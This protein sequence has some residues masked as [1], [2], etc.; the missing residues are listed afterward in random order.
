[1]EFLQSILIH[2]GCGGVGL[3]AIQIAQ[4]LGAEI[5]TTVSSEAKIRYLMDTYGIPRNRIFNSRSTSFV[6]EL[7]R[8]TNGGGVDLAL[9]SLS[10]EQ[11]H[12]TWSCVAK[13]GTMVEIGKRDLL[14]AAK[15]DMTPFLANRNYCCVDLDQM[16]RERPQMVGK[17]LRYMMDCYRQGHVQPVRIERVVNAAAIQEAFRFMQQGKHIGKIVLQLRD[18]KGTLELGEIDTKKKGGA[19]LDENAS[20][21]LVGGLGGLGRAMSV[22]MVNHGARNLTFLSRSAGKTQS[23]DDFVQE[24]G[25]MGCT[26]Q[27]VQGDVTNADDVARAVEGALAPLK[28][29]IQM[30]MVLRDQM[31]D[32]MSLEDWHAVS[33]P[34]VQGTWN[35]HEATISRN[36]ELDLF[37][38][39]SSLSG[40]VGQ[41]GQANYA[42][43]NT[44]LDSF[45][46]YRA[47]MGLAC[48]A[49]DLGAMDGVGY[50][51][52]NQDLLRKMQGTGWRVVQEGELLEGLEAAM[53]STPARSQAKQSAFRGAFLL[54]ISPS[55]PL[56]S[57]DSNARLRRDARMAVYHNVGSQ[58]NKSVSA[59]DG[60]RAFMKSIKS[61][62]NTLKSA[63]SVTFLATEIGKKLFSLLLKSEDDGINVKMNT[64]D[65]GLDSLVAVEL[66]SWWKLSFGFDIALLEMLSMGTLDALGKFAAEKL[67]VLYG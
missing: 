7:L 58:S 13:W 21:L 34:K 16:S 48:S 36:I 39:F 15:L 44:F 49:I 18:E 24:I 66:R 19:Q 11:L 55:V 17:L 41:T 50:L 43:A 46:Q 63:D 54:G 22:W 3:A 12:A 10:G 47:S 40:I 67:L 51:S 42:A 9:N 32:G 28:G 1:M 14:G 59:N 23:D 6:D 45:V 52:K 25:S 2:S 64:A 35:L 8:E 56:S 53:M 27:L 33:R 60:L 61:D 38:L 31:F 57:P 37:L 5:F 4:M 29:I 30:S 26:V 20:Y 62:P 65:I